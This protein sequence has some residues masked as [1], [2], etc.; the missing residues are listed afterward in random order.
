MPVIYAD[1]LLVLN[2]LIDYLLLSATAALMHLPSRTWRLVL[3][4]FLGGCS[5]CTA[6]IPSLSPLI[7]TAVRLIT[8]GG[9]TWIAFP[10]HGGKEWLRRTAVMFILSS[11]LAGLAFA[12]WYFAAP[13]GFFVLNGAIY[14][15]VSPLTLTVL[16]VIGYG[17]LWLF[18]HLFHRQAP[19]NRLYRLMIDAGNGE[20]SITALYDTGC[21]LTEPFSGKPVII[22]KREAVAATLPAQNT[23]WIPFETLSGD[24]LLPAY[25]LQ[26]AAVVLPGGRQQELGSI[27]LAVTDRLG[28]SECD[29]LFGTDVGALIKKEKESIG[30]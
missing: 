22:A 14:Y 1:I 12:L 19:A 17:A 28:Q 26:R 13:D 30:I 4:S 2:W 29:A 15:H 11:A 10:W 3:A 24:G 5:A 8:A 25:P 21:H 6:L 20:V 27:Y 18:G 23:R 16:S 7:S 9:M